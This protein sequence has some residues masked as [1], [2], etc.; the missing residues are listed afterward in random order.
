MASLSRDYL[1]SA[2][3]SRVK[4]ATPEAPAHAYIHAQASRAY[5]LYLNTRQWRVNYRTGRV[6]CDELALPLITAQ[7]LSS[8]LCSL[9]LSH[10]LLLSLGRIRERLEEDALSARLSAP[11]CRG[12]SA[13]LF[14]LSYL[15]LPMFLR[16]CYLRSTARH[17]RFSYGFLC[18]VVE[19]Y[20][21]AAIEI[22]PVAL[23]LYIYTNFF[24]L[25]T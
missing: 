14:F 8:P 15:L 3:D 16:V 17:R 9:S 7:H 20:H 4:Q 18:V 10:S 6:I 19:F 5:R 22:R 25:F 24:V 21:R 2:R 13:E 12:C 23:A 1:V 11:F